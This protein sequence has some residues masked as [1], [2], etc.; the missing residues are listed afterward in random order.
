M[1]ELR[2]SSNPDAEA[3]A[4]A[5]RARPAP[6]PLPRLLYRAS[7][8]ATMTG[9]SPSK[10]YALMACGDLPTVKIGTAVRVRASDLEDWL[11]ALALGRHG[12]LG[13]A[14]GPIR[15]SPDRRRV[16]S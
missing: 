16:A 8:V 1:I 14:V 15:R 2:A 6:P 12:L 13:H 5:E 7:E 3:R 4:T 10:V 11:E 9:L